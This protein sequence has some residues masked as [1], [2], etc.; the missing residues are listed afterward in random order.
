MEPTVQRFEVKEYPVTNG[1]LLFGG[2]ILSPFRLKNATC[3][4]Q[5]DPGKKAYKVRFG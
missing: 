3:E 1:C 2:L 4:V 5:T